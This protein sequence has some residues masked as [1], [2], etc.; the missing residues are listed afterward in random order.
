MVKLILFF[1]YSVRVKRWVQEEFLDS[2]LYQEPSQKNHSTQ[3]FFLL[4]AEAVVRAN[5]FSVMVSVLMIKPQVEELR[6]LLL[7]YQTPALAA[8]PTVQPPP[9]MDEEVPGEEEEDEEAE[10][11]DVNL[12]SEMEKMNLV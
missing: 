7:R 9:S 6:D 3:P 2:S 1:R 4:P 5:A 12:K 8:P 10:E 11:G